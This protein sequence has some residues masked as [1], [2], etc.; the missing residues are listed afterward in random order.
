MMKKIGFICLLLV[1]SFVQGMDADN[2][3]MNLEE[4][5]TVIAE[6]KLCN[7]LDGSNAVYYYSTKTPE[8]ALEVT[9]LREGIITESV[10]I[11]YL[12]KEWNRFPVCPCHEP[13]CKSRYSFVMLIDNNTFEPSCNRCGLPKSFE[14]FSSGKRKAEGQDR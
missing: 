4:A 10:K 9:D 5:R 7:Y 8:M 2:S 14:E 11:K 6:S 3:G 12:K 13:S 1:G